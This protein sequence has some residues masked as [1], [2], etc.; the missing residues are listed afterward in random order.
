MKPNPVEREINDIRV[1]IYE[2]TKGMSP[3]E[4]TAY[5]KRQVAPIHKK[6]RFQMVPTAR[7]GGTASYAE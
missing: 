2:E 1:K 7:S 5:I 3:S 4:M 6:Y